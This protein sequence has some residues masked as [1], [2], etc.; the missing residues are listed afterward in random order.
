MNYDYRKIMHY[1]KRQYGLIINHKKVY[2]L[3]KELDILKNQRAIKPKVKRSIAA[4]RII[5][6]SN[7]LWEMD[8]K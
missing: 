2:R 3:C 5:T 8:I 4:N 6:D 1:L 7:Q